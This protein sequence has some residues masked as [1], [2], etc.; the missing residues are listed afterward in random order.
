LLEDV[1]NDF[2]KNITEMKKS[3]SK[4]ETKHEDIIKQYTFLADTGYVSNNALEFIENNSIN[5]IIDT[6][7]KTIENNAFY[8][9]TPEKI[10]KLD[11]IKS[12][13]HLRYNS[14]A[15]SYVCI[16]NEKFELIEEKTINYNFN[17][18]KDIPEE[19][20]KINYV[21]KNNACINC[22]IKDKCNDGKDSQIINDK[23]TPI[24]KKARQK[25]HTHESDE[26]YK[27]RWK[28]IESIFAYLKGGD[29]VLRFL[30][31]KLEDIQKELYLMSI[32]YNLK[33]ITKLKD[34]PYE[35]NSSQIK[36]KNNLNEILFLN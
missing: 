15:D 33:R 17:K 29:G 24:N 13:K 18:Q 20:K 5:A 4:E 32:T 6:R 22:D 8:F 2:I 27:I 30:Q 34:V 36:W 12:K 14:I 35:K 21:Y 25:R 1:I 10:D 19:Y 26:I 23:I 9:L 16:K 28:T 3:T 7:L 11:N 31:G